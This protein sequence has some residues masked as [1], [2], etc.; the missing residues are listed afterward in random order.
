MTILPA[1][2]LAEA[3]ETTRIYSIAGLTGDRAMC[4]TTRP[5]RAPHQAIS[6]GGV[7]DSRLVKTSPSCLGSK[8]ALPSQY[9]IMQ[10]T[11][12]TH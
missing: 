12:F 4:V 11:F 10:G 6:E 1:M 3:I 2:T 9:I 7:I 8:L 5:F